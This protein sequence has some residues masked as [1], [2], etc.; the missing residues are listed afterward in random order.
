MKK[1]IVPIVSL[2]LA[3]FFGYTLTQSEQNLLEE[4]VGGSENTTTSIFHSENTDELFEVI[5]VADGDTVTVSMNG[6]LEK[7]RFIG[8]DTPEIGDSKN[9][10]DCLAEEAKKEIENLIDGHK[11]RLE[12]DQSQGERDKY[13][14]VLAYVF[15]DDGLFLNRH[16]IQK[17]FAHE[18]TYQKKYKYID[19]FIQD[20]ERAQLEQVGIWNH[21]VCLPELM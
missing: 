5:K 13:G 9:P 6:N 18:Y 1:K 12:F 16:M 4:I 10:S 7:V 21:D 14:R 3:I 11:V 19:D 2:L 20:E 17:G 8:I 15:L